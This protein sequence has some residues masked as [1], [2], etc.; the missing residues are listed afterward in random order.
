M[1]L[2][3]LTKIFG[4][5]LLLTVSFSC[6]DDD[7]MTGGGTTGGGGTMENPTAS[8]TFA[9]DAN[10]PFT[11][12]FSNGSTNAS[13]YTWDFGDGESATEESP[14]HTYAE[15]GVFAVTLTATEGASSRATTMD[16]T[17]IDPGADLRA[18]AGE[19]TKT[20]KLL[21]D[22]S[23]GMDFPVAV[24]PA[25]RSQVW[26]AIGRD[27][28]IGTR[29]CLMEEEYIFSVDGGYEYKTNGSVFAEAGVWAESLEGACVDETDP[30]NMININGEDISAWGSN[31]TYT[32]DFDIDNNTL[33]LIGLGAHVGLSK[34]G[35]DAEYINPQDAVTYNIVSLEDNDG[36]DRM[37][38]ETAIPG[39][40]WRFILV[41]YDDPATEPSLPAPPPIVN[42]DFTIDNNTVT[43]SNNSQFADSYV[44]D[45][46]DGMT[47]TEEAPVHTYAGDGVYTVTL[48]GFNMVGETTAFTDITI[49]SESF[50]ATKLFGSGSKVWK[51][52]PAAGAL[53]VGSFKGGGDFFATG[54]ADIMGRS[55][56]FDD[57]FEFTD[58]GGFNYD[59]TG[60]VFAEPYMGVVDAGCINE[61]DLTGGAEAWASGMHT[62]TVEE[63]AGDD[64]AFITVKG[65]GAFIAL[66]KAF[67]GGEHADA[68]TI[69]VDGEIRY[70]V[71]NYV[72]GVDGE[73]LQITLDISEGQV[74]GAWWTF[75]LRAD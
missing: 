62:Y 31:D 4:F 13:S 6:N 51:L 19:T 29:T 7:T 43:F 60:Q 67:N 14:S 58:M 26:F 37:I 64:P 30:M 15:G 74:G 56:A 66:P 22:I 70:E 32:Y 73:I 27:E 53:S 21:R 10:D 17:V 69:Q 52:N 47:S 18:L 24:G 23:S 9:A 48:R 2:L 28:P 57:E 39:G 12:I 8:F 36:V 33:S 35:T 68:S 3:N 75:T 20:W 72:N 25:D 41:S 49:S 44:W 50:S 40:Y 45:F 38:L 11:I 34:A 63:A 59:A 5:L 16:V 46:G 71:L 61:G 1:Y 65:T 54:E 55:C 42:F